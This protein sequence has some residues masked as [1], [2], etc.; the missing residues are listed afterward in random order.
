MTGPEQVDALRA[1]GWR[2]LEGDKVFR[3]LAPGEHPQHGWENIAA[4]ADGS[5]HLVQERSD[6]HRRIAAVVNGL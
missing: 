5:M 2:V 3:V 6:T 1:A 4:N